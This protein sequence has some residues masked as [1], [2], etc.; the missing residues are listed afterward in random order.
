MQNFQPDRGC[1]LDRRQLLLSGSAMIAGMALRAGRARGS[2][3]ELFVSCRFEPASGH[4]VTGIDTIGN[5]RFD[6]PLPDRGHGI[7]FRPG[8]DEGV[9]FARRPGTFAVA[10]DPVAG[11]A[12]RRIDAAEGRHFYGHGAFSPDG[13]Y[14]F[15][16][17]NDWQN[18]RGVLAIRDAT[19][20]YR[21]L[22][23]FASHGIGPHEVVLMPDG[24]TLAVANGGILTRPDRD[25][26]KLNLDDMTPSLAYVDL[27]DGKLCA[28]YRLAEDLR[29]LSI[30]HLAVLA[31]GG[32]AITM[33]YE[34]SKQD[35]VPLVGIHDGDRI[36][37]L[38]APEGV[39]RRMRQYGG[40]VAADQEGRLIAVSAPRGDVVTF[41]DAVQGV[42]L[43]S[44]RLQ[45][46]CG[47]SP[48]D[49]AGAFLITS[50]LGDIL[51][52]EPRTG[53]RQPLAFAALGPSSWDNHLR[54]RV[55]PA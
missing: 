23:E 33:Q 52:F 5:V 7:T 36:R 21:Q 9:V 41:W 44:I 19:D 3:G 29:R 53:R 46:G 2:A 8:A 11:I 16:T 20:G 47:V 25:R 40:G 43:T 4:H 26:A 39:Q 32:V 35:R 34:G 48:T 28:D 15:T 17:E 27:A 51:C 45:D 38:E 55:A 54:M 30:R 22:G 31:S 13:R 42:Y 10:F 24:A 14:L 18:G 6:L 1:C 50:G 37:L 49:Q 12:L